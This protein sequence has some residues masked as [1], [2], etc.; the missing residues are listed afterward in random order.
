MTRKDIKEGM[1]IKFSSGNWYRII[2]HNSN[3]HILDES[4]YILH[5]SLETYANE[6]LAPYM[7]YNSIVEIQTAKCE[8]IWSKPVEMTVS[9]I[10]KALKLTPGTLRIKTE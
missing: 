1:R 4:R 3:L 6:D 5:K 2:L 10:E 9:E 8:T 7:G